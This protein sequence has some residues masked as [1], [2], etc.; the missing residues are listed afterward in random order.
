MKYLITMA[1]MVGC[2]TVFGQKTI[3]GNWKS[4]EKY[5]L[6]YGKRNLVKLI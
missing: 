5:L 6:V 3:D 4:K 2:L 1:F